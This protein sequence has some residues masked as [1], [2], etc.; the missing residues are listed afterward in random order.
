MPF[1]YQVDKSYEYYLNNWYVEM[2]L[3]CESPTAISFMYMQYFI[4]AMAGGLL[5]AL[6]DRIGRKKSVILG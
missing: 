2:D 4:G 3:M 1:E 6:P 5:S